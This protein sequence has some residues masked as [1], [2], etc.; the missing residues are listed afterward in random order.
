M[1]RTKLRW[2]CCGFM[3]LAGAAWPAMASAQSTPQTGTSSSVPAQTPPRL[4]PLVEKD[5]SDG[6][7]SL[8]ADLIA[9]KSRFPFKITD[10]NDHLIGMYRVLAYAPSIGQGI[11][12]LGNRWS[13]SRILTR[14]MQE[15]AI[16][17]T[18]AA[19]RASYVWYAHEHL[20]TGLFSKQEIDAMRERRPLKL[21]DPREQFV[22]DMSRSLAEHG[23]IDDSLYNRGVEQIGHEGIVELTWIIGVYRIDTLQLRVHRLSGAPEDAFAPAGK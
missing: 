1:V 22:N 16:L 23:D 7:K 19:D 17:N 6:R 14:R 15:I 5:L 12:D 3:L 8:N 18:A 21:S 20:S 10:E 9:Q 11:I 2:A 13:Q 4:P